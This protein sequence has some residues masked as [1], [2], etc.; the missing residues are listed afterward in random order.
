MPTGSADVQTSSKAPRG[1]R[2]AIVDTPDGRNWRHLD[3]IHRR[4]PMSPVVPKAEASDSVPPCPDNAEPQA[5]VRKERLSL[6]IP[7]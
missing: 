3:R 1:S 6:A 2:L 5:S 4:V 7:V